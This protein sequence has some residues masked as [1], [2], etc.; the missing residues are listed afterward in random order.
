MPEEKTKLLELLDHQAHWCRDAE[1]RDCEGEAVRYDDDLAVAWDITGAVCRLF[2]W[3]RACTLFAQI[4][5]HFNGRPKYYGWPGRD[6]E[7]EAMR[8]L[9][10]FNDRAETT[11]EAL[12]SRLESLPVWS[13][14]SNRA[15]PPPLGKAEI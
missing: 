5:R 13:K 15:S 11:F 14:G 1:A 2:G 3:K 4:E 9:Q 8:A 7:M 6:I 12:R 10:N